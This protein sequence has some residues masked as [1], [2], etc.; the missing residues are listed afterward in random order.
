[1]STPQT[2]QASSTILAVGCIWLLL[3]APCDIFDIV[4]TAN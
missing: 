2:G 3:S 1:M 4:A